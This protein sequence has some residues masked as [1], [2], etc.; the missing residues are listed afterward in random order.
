MNG[1][2]W[3]VWFRQPEHEAMHGNITADA[4]RDREQQRKR[5]ARRSRELSRRIGDVGENRKQES[6]S[7]NRGTT[8]RWECFLRVRI[9]AR[10]VPRP[11]CPDVNTHSAAM[12][13]K[14]SG[15][16]ARHRP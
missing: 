7:C 14:N 8:E 3:R 15:D 13:T 4:K 11:E 16:S 12:L 2:E 5:E 6:F 9:V 1:R 10:S